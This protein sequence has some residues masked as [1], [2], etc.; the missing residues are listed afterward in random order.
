MNFAF[1]LR[2]IPESG[3]AGGADSWCPGTAGEPRLATPLAC[4]K[5]DDIHMPRASKGNLMAA[6]SALDG[7]DG[8]RHSHSV[9]L[10]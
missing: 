5:F 7:S 6:A 10:G 9:L 2:R 4:V 1:L 3:F 8:F